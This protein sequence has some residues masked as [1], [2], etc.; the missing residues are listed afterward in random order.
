VC[1]IAYLAAQKWTIFKNQVK[2]KIDSRAH[3]GEFMVDILQKIKVE[4]LMYLVKT[5]EPVMQDM[6]FSQFKKFFSETK[7][8]Y[9][10]VINSDNRLV[11]IFS[12]TDIRGVIFSGEIEELVVMKDIA[13]TDIIVTT[14]SED[15]NTVLQKLT[16]RNIDSL[17]VVRED[18]HGILI[19]MLDRR[20][21]IA[22]YNRQIERLKSS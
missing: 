2:S 18:D 21:V 20:A 3:A 9:F 17:P 6:T 15:L 7:Q 16:T 10:P 12:S 4:N 19:G 13:T 14:P 8:H 22:N 11:G 5:V 1:S